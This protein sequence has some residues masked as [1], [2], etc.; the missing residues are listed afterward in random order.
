MEK[1]ARKEY[2]PLYELMIED[3]L[4]EIRRFDGFISEAEAGDIA[5]K[6]RSGDKSFDPWIEG[7]ESPLTF[8]ALKTLTTVEVTELG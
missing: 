4:G 7:M 1:G 2:P 8:K 3:F 6:I 5:A